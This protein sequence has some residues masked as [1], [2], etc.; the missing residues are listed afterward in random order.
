METK[1]AV[2]RIVDDIVVLENLDNGVISYIYRSFLDFPVNEKDIIIHKDDSFYKDEDEYNK[3]IEII[4]D[5]FE[6]LKRR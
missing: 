2:D 1:F 4:K 5:K 6:R 3:R